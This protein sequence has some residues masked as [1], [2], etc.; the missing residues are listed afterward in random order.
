MAAGGHPQPLVR[1]LNDGV[2]NGRVL[3]SLKLGVVAS[4]LSAQDAGL[5]H[6]LHLAGCWVRVMDVS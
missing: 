4:S 1:V 5:V 2:E 3:T 6:L